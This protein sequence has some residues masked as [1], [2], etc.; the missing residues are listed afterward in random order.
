MDIDDIIKFEDYNI[1]SKE[2]PFLRETFTGKMRG[3]AFPLALTSPIGILIKIALHRSKAR[4]IL[5]QGRPRC[6]RFTGN[7][8]KKC[9][10]DV[11]KVFAENNIRELERAKRDCGKQGTPEKVRMCNDKI[12]ERIAIE[13]E[14]VKQSTRMAGIFQATA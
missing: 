12:N 14:K 7:E 8:K 4:K 6:D 9:L 5:E 13:Q 2:L 1:L 3:I 10:Q 11:K